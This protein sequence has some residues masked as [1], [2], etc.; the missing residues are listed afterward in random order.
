MFSL[1]STPASL[2]LASPIL[3]ASSSSPS[4]TPYSTASSPP[5]QSHS[6]S[7][8]PKPP[9]SP[10]SV[11]L[12]RSSAMNIVVGAAAAVGTGTMRRSSLSD[13]KIP[14]RISQAQVGLRRDLSMVR[15]FARNVEELK[16]LQGTY[17]TLASEVQGILDMHVLHPSKEEKDP[18]CTSPT[19]FKRHCS[20]TSSSTDAPSPTIQQQSQQAYKQLTSAFYTINS[21]YRIS[22][23]C[24][25]LLIE[26]GGGGSS[27]SP[28]RTSTS[29]P[30]MQQSVGRSEGLKSKREQ[31]IA[32]QDA[33]KVPPS[34]G[35]LTTTPS[36]P[37]P[38]LARPPN[39]LACRAS[40]KRN[41]LS[42]RQLLLLKEMLN[43]TPG[44]PDESFAEDIPE[45]T[46]AATGSSATVNR[47]WRRG[48]AMNSTVTLPSKE[49]GVQ[50]GVP[51]KEQKWRSSRMRMSGIR[52]M[53][54]ALTKGGGTPPVP[55][56][57]T[58]VSTESSSVLHAQH[59]YQHRQV[60]QSQSRRAKA[61]AGPESASIRS[62]H[63]PLSPFDPSSLKTA[64]PRRP[65]LASIFRIGKGKI[66]PPFAVADASL[67]NHEVY[68]TFSGISGGRES[69]STSI[70]DE[71]DWDRMEDSASAR[72]GGSTIQG[73]SPYMYTS[74]LTPASGRPTTVMRLSGSRTSIQDLPVGAPA[75]ATRLS[76]VEEHTDGKSTA[77]AESPLAQLFSRSRLGGKTGSVRSMPPTPPD[78]K[79][80][81]TPENIKPLLENAREVHA[82]LSDCI[83]EI[84]SLVA[85]QKTEK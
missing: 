62:T 58:S 61:S 44:G 39:Y 71:E 11:S 38:P 75:R 33:A 57:L 9:A 84:R 63:R 50:G 53:L 48:D 79:L 23:E 47:D 59:L 80:A 40:T 42:Q 65:S 54:R 10:Q 31:A 72:R 17:Q 7:P 12:G 35:P 8:S 69:A 21:K 16:E 68:A 60:K 73:R 14:A 26:L 28:P 1:V 46:V 2:S 27:S 24:A 6:T 83:A 37:C 19:F 18:A 20:N 41:D 51:S 29:A 22:W 66:P 56:S 5:L 67:D 85:A 36:L 43:P 4:L 64:S 52:D 49:G 30:A 45:E 76:N 25:E 74:F 70:G 32:L 3:L 78:P 82:R 55:V 81:M 15:E 34:P 77:K 13:L